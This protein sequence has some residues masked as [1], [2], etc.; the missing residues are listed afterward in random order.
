MCTAI[1]I[2]D[3]KT[4]KRAIAD[5]I[6][7]KV[8]KINPKGLFVSPYQYTIYV[9]NKLVKA[10]MRFTSKSGFADGTEYNYVM[11]NGGEDKFA[12]VQTGFHSFTSIERAKIH[13]GRDLFYSIGEF[14]IPKGS[15]YYENG[16]GNIVSNQIIFKE[17]KPW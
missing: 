17:I 16:C 6:V 1:L 12:Y 13:A 15:K 4:P 3:A 14:I 10:A 5:I 2:A 7:Y 8:G 11:I 9:P